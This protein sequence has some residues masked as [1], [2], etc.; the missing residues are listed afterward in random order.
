MPKKKETDVSS[1]E[2]SRVIC[3]ITGDSGA[4]KSFFIANI[5]NALVYD[6]DMGGGLRYADARIQKNES[7]R[8]EASS[9]IEV[10][11]DIKARSKNGGLKPTIAIDHATSLHQEAELRHNPQQDAD[12]GR[13]SKMATAEWRRLRG[14]L[15]NLDCN[16]FLTAHMKS[17]FKGGEI[18]GVTTDGAKNIEGDADI[19]LYLHHQKGTGYPSSA[20]VIKWRRDPDDP[21]GPV[22]PMFPFTFEEFSKIS[23]G[24]MARER[25]DVRLVS[26]ETLTT[27]ISLLEKVKVEDTTKKRWLSKSGVSKWEDMSEDQALKVITHLHKQVTG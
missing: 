9:W 12:F 5:K 27:M 16:I 7:E 1:W 6:T 11:D 23:G 25:Q 22:K 10:I 3:T 2:D 26:T 4:G 18:T 20:Q 24:G 14:L 21:R 8:I 13:S 17:E 19:N 15:R